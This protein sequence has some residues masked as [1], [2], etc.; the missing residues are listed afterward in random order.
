MRELQS[1]LEISYDRVAQHYAD[2]YFEELKR[3]P[4][5]QELL[6]QFAAS[7]H[8][9]GL[10]CDLGCGPGQ[11]ARYL[12]DCGVDVCGID[13]SLEMVRCARQLNPDISFEQGDMLA[14]NAPDGSFAGIVSY[15][16]IIHLRREEVP[17]ALRE[18]HRV[19]Q[20]GGKLL[21]AFHGGE[22]GFHRDEWY[23]EPVS[24]DVTLFEGQEMADYLT[25]AGF[26]IER[27]AQREPYSFEYPTR[28]V[29]VLGRKPLL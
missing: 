7:V 21:L 13:L 1:E 24:I 23:G 26:E 10:V 20:L 2:E 4:F 8:D 15:Y 27:I 17:R 12:R 3:K 29:Y 16:A 18:L 19:L 5:D 9:R 25:E 22:G 14:L 6:D 11:V 28:R